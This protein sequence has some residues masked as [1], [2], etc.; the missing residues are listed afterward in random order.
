M[1][2]K[3]LESLGEAPNFNRSCCSHYNDTVAAKF[4]IHVCSLYM[5][6]RFIC[7]WM[8][9]K[10]MWILIAMLSISD[11]TLTTGSVAEVMESM[12]NWDLLN[13]S[14]I[15]KKIVPGSRLAEI[16]QRYSTKR[17]IANECASFYVH[18]YPQPSWTHLASQLY[19]AGEFAAV[20]KLKP[21][22]PLRGKCQTISK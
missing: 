13:P 9:L 6:V 12:N 2:T 4:C 11:P 7:R 21:F 22:L 18:C 5:F 17:E 14:Y 16:R 19:R 10:T 20:E 15:T 8:L 1:C 3:Y